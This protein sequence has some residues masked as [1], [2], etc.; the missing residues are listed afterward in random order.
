M[1]NKDKRAA[2]SSLTTY[3]LRLTTYDLPHTLPIWKVRCGQ[4]D[5]ANPRQ[6]LAVAGI[7]IM[8]MATGCLASP[9]F[10][11]PRALSS[12]VFS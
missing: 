1:S 10:C 2:R 7:R 9:C 3:D 4:I 6:H 5:Y 8:S 12:S 11:F